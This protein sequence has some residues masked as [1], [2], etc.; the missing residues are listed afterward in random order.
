M[1]IIVIVKII[2]DLII[3]IHND[4]TKMKT[5]ILALW[6]FALL[7]ATFGLSSNTYAGTWCLGTGTNCNT[8]TQVQVTILPGTVCI[9][10]TGNFNFGSYVVSSAVQTVNWAFTSPFYVDDLKGADSGYYTTVQINAALAGP[11]GATIPAANIYMKTAAT[12]NPG[13]TTLAGTANTRVIIHAGMA[14]YQSLDTARQLINRNT[15]AN[16]GVLGQ[17]WVNPQMQLV[18]PAY[19]SV[20][21]YTGTL[22]YTLYEN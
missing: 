9:G 19:Q 3:Y 7:A 6:A 17:Y 21:T 15:A 13:I 2:N 22:T 1:Y 8:T 10:S 16:F 11:G 4:K 20:G 18:I 12:G 14:G 5:K